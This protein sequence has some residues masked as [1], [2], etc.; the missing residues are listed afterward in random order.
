MPRDVVLVTGASSDIGLTLLR[1]LLAR[2]EKPIV[3]AHCHTG[4]GRIL[5]LCKELGSDHI[6]PVEMDLTKTESFSE[7]LGRIESEYGIPNQ[8]VHLPAQKLVYQRFS[9]FD[10][11]HFHRDLQIQLQSAVLLLKELMPRMAQ[12]DSARVVFLLSSITR[13]MPPK[14]LSMYTIVKYAQLGLM[15]SLASEYA[16]TKVT[17]NAVSPSMVATRFLADVPE[18]A[19]RLSA[20]QNPKGRNATP[21][22]V[23]GAMEFLLSEGSS[24]I[25]GVEIPVAAGSV[26]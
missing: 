2:K 16:E 24:Y 15:R 20:C 14:F 19:V 9:K 8:F 25:T 6:V 23:V 12:L 5:D 10:W 22:D 18:V 3:I 1:R 13:N 7:M 4:R 17:V 11:C 26:C 21:D